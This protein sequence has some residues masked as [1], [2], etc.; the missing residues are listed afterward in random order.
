MK[1]TEDIAF[2]EQKIQKLVQA[3]GDVANR[4]LTIPK[5]EQTEKETH[6][7]VGEARVRNHVS[8]VS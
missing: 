5:P 7:W 3:M 2:Q 8:T 6:A 4:I 1:Y